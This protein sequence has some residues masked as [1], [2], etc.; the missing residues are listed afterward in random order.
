MRR[1]L[2]LPERLE[3]EEAETDSVNSDFEKARGRSKG[4]RKKIEKII[5]RDAND[6][7]NDVTIAKI[8]A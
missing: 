3:K 4:K 7:K 8:E 2:Q 1:R 5:Y 6:E